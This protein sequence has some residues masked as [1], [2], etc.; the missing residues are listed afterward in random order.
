MKTR[1]KYASY[2]VLEQY[3]YI[4]GNEHSNAPRS[5]KHNWMNAGR[6]RI[7]QLA[8]RDG[9][10]ELANIHKQSLRHSYDS[11]MHT[12]DFFMATIHQSKALIKYYRKNRVELLFMIDKLKAFVPLDE[13]LTVFELTRQT[14]TSLKNK[15]ACKLSPSNACLNS[16][17]NQFHN[18]LVLEMKTLYFDNVNYIEFSLS[19]LFA[20]VIHDRKLFISYTKFREIAIS[21]GEDIKRKKKI[22]STKVEGLKSYYPNQFIQADKT[23]YKLTSGKKVWIYLVGDNYSRKLLAVHVSYSS[24]SFE[25]VFTLKKAIADNDLNGL[26]FI[27]ITDA[28]SEN[29]HLVKEFI[30]TQAN[31]THLIAQTNEMTFSNSMIEA[32]IKYFKNNILLNK[33]FKTIEELELAVNLGIE[34]YNNRHRKFL[35]GGTPNDFYKGNEPN[36][37]EYRELYKASTEKRIQENKTFNCMKPCQIP[38]LK[39]MME[40]G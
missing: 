39:P 30:K 6:E 25:S 1:G 26:N 19:D 20:R 31:I 23:A 27:Y 17:T 34:T 35:N 3:N 9:L 28:G 16:V 24:K 33:S 10:I 37:I 4:I 5:T 32:I 8:T 36:M 11:I 22:K 7:E 21:L 14:Y 40:F 18:D 2:S 13:L 29:K 38:I 12:L 15:L